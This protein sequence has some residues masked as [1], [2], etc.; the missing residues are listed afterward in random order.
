MALEKRQSTA[1]GVDVLYW[2]ITQVRVLY[3]TDEAVVV[4]GGYISR[5]ARQT[6]GAA[7]LIVQAFSLKDTLEGADARQSAYPLIKQKPEFAGA[8]DA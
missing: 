1:F 8:A 4:V 7:P 2:R 5:E 3:E 6:P